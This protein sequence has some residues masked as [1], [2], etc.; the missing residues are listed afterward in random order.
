MYFWLN[1]SVLMLELSNC[2]LVIAGKRCPLRLL[3]FGRVWILSKLDN[4]FLTV[5]IFMRISKLIYVRLLRHTCLFGLFTKNL[6]DY[7][8]NPSLIAS[9]LSS[10]LLA[11]I[12]C[13]WHSLGVICINYNFNSSLQP[14]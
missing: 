10:I 9:L 6:P 1:C 2:A 8:L 12:C 7:Q 3:G 5:K 4:T 13:F 11:K 14:H